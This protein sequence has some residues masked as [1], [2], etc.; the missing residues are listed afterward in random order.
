MGCSSPSSP[1][2][3]STHAPHESER[4]YPLARLS[5]VKHLPSTDVMP[6]SANA[7]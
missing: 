7:R 3:W 1:A 4:Q 6:A 2:T 5:H